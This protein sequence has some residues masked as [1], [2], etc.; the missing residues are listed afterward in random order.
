MSIPTPDDS[1]SGR[2][3][4]LILTPMLDEDAPNDDDGA[5]S[6]WHFVDLD[7][8]KRHTGRRVDQVKVNKCRCWLV[9]CSFRKFHL[10]SS[11][12]Y[13]LLG[14]RL[15]QCASYVICGIGGEGE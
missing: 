10:A 1:V 5:P 7:T 13:S 9:I 6:R 11:A 15:L 2:L 8:H 3:V 4:T 12:P 14:G